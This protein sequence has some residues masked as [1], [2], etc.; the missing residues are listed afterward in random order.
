MQVPTSTVV[1]RLPT[2]G[3]KE[4]FGMVFERGSTL[5]SCVNH[6]LAAMRASGTLNR[7]EK[8]WLAGGAPLLKG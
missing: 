8:K 6:A 1:G 5:D 2:K 3:T 7:L 4:R